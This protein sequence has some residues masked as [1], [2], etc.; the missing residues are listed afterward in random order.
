MG[1]ELT[2][3]SLLG[4]GVLTS[5]VLTV[6]AL[7]HRSAVRAHATR[8]DNWFEAWKLERKVSAETA[9]QLTRVVSAVRTVSEEM[10]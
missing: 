4:E 3:I 5:A 2:L 7:F 8:A 6:L 10:P 9:Q 1:D